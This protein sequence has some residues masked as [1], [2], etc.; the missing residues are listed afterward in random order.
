MT[1]NNG[2]PVDALTLSA[3]GSFTFATQLPYLGSYAVTVGAQPAG[4]TCTLSNASGSNVAANVTNVAVSC[5]YPPVYAYVANDGNDTISQFSLAGDGSLAPLS[6]AVV[7]T[8][9][10][11]FSIRF[12]PSGHFAYVAN[13]GEQLTFAPDPVTFTPG[14]VSQYAVGAGG[15][16]APLAT[17]TVSTD[18]GPESVTIDPTGQFA[19]VANYWSNSIAPYSIGVDGSLAALGASVSTGEAPV[20]SLIDPSGKF[21]YVVCFNDNLVM[22]FS[23]GVDGSLSALTPYFVAVGPLPVAI[24]I[25][26]AGKYAYVANDG[27]NTVSQ[28]AIG[29]DGALAPLTPATVQAGS[30]VGGAGAYALVVDRT[31]HFVY[32]AN[33]V[34]ATVALYTIGTDGAL[35]A[36]GSIWP[37]G[38]SPTSYPT[39]ASIDPTGRF[40]IVGNNGDDS[41]T[42]FAIGANGMLTSLGN[43]STGT[44]S[45]PHGVTTAY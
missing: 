10:K 28:F 37:T 31:S 36:S 9:S 33:A 27:D 45:V 30:T 5:S 12:H 41:V 15:V 16:L 13:H 1:L 2:A 39:S 4:Q 7:A 40:L 21:F 42:R 8:G 25:D 18:S 17:A 22:Q 43:T 19:Y 26:P 20:A 24:A 38:S 3:N 14:T 34:D 44:G 32:V 29:V 6:P 35:T 23:I 11:P